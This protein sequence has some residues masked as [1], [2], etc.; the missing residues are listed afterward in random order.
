MD[1]ILLVYLIVEL[2]VIVSFFLFL[3]VKDLLWCNLIFLLFLLFFCER[4][5]MYFWVWMDIVVWYD[6]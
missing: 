2:K 6:V 1:K 3:F 5:S 4:S